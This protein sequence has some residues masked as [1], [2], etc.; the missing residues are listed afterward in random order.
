VRYQAALHPE[1]LEF[2][3]PGSVFLVPFPGSPLDQL[4]PDRVG[5]KWFKS[6]H[7]EQRTTNREHEPGTSNPE[8]GT[9]RQRDARD[10]RFAELL[11]LGDGIAL[12]DAIFVRAGSD[13][14]A[15]TGR[16]FGRATTDGGVS[17]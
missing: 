7:L 2:L 8:R 5:C 16:G 6:E 12:R 14:R 15:A 4:G 1:A 17:S 9:A 3:V 10:T 11:P 13:F